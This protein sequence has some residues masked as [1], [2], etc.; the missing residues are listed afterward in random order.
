[1]LA[2]LLWLGPRL[3]QELFP[4]VG[5]T[6]FRLRFD[7]STGTRAEDTE[8]LVARV[9]EQIRQAA[10]PENIAITL[11]YV[12]TQGASYPIN[13][14]FLWTSG[15][16]E[17]VINVALR[18]EAHIDVSVLKEN[19][20]QMLPPQ[21]PGSTFSFEPGDLVSQIMNFGAPTPVEIAV[22]KDDVLV[23]QRVL[24]PSWEQFDTLMREARRQAQAA[25]LRARHL[26]RV[27]AK[28]RSA[29]ARGE[30]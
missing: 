14:V 13:T 3:G 7:A 26:K 21:F 30:R 19:L 16:H 5:A 12:G 11:G 22:V 29:K 17:A 23:F 2:I 24:S 27:I 8:L 18:P 10:G 4:N 6:Q 25:G 9:L 28:V 15:P 20:R 1:M